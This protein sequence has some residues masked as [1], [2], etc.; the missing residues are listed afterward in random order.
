VPNIHGFSALFVFL[1]CLRRDFFNPQL[2]GAGAVPPGT[3]TGGD[4]T[5]FLI[6]HDEKFNQ[7]TTCNTSQEKWAMV[8]FNGDTTADWCGAGTSFGRRGRGI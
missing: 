4:I 2:G 8:R 1:K 3:T 5:P 7:T 6:D